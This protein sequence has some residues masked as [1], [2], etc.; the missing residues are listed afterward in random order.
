MRPRPS[1]RRVCAQDCGL[2][3]RGRPWSWALTPPEPLP[4]LA[5]APL[6]PCGSADSFS[7]VTGM[8]VMRWELGWRP[9]PPTG[10]RPFW[11]AEPGLPAPPV[12]TDPPG[13]SLC[14]RVLA[15]RL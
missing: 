14:A 12:D 13:L 4:L 3:S 6:C 10:H 5:A 1:R 8:R 15:P 7:S 2:R 11:G 9:R